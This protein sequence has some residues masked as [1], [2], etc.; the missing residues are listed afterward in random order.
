M[1]LEM[2]AGYVWSCHGVAHAALVPVARVCLGLGCS[3]KNGW[4]RM[5]VCELPK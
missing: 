5:L 3:V 1:F 4:E 2:Y